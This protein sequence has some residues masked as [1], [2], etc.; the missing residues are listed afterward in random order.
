MRNTNLI[1]TII[2]APTDS[3]IS[4][5]LEVDS[6]IFKNF[7]HVSFEDETGGPCKD[8]TILQRKE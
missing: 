4:A 8:G 7:K 6:K 2:L 5:W 3:L 1:R